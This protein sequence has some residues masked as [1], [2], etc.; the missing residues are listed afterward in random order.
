MSAIFTQPASQPVHISFIDYKGKQHL[1]IPHYFKDYE[2]PPYAAK[3][4]QLWKEIL[5]EY[6][7][8]LNRDRACELPQ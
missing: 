3:K 6:Y 2:S 7:D 1:D 8:R 4:M 5:H